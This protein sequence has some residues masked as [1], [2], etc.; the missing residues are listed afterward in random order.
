MKKLFYILAALAV[1]VVVYLLYVI[2]TDLR[3]GEK[4]VFN[5]FANAKAKLKALVSGVFK[6]TPSVPA[7][8]N[9]GYVDPNQQVTLWDGSTFDVM[10][11]GPG[12]F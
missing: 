1:A 6:S 4:S 11:Y 3:A 9:P 2:I 10:N 7:V 5:A 8:V 12:S